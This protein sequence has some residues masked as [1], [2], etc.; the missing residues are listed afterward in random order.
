MLTKIWVWSHMVSL[1]RVISI[2]RISW[3]TDRKWIRYGC[4]LLLYI[5]CVLWVL[6]YTLHFLYLVLFLSL[7]DN[8]SLVANVI[9]LLKPTW[10]KVYLI[11]SYLILLWY[12][13][14]TTS[15]KA[16]FWPDFKLMKDT[17]NSSYGCLSWDNHYNDVIM[18]MTAS[19]ITRLM[20]VY[21]TAYS[22]ADQ[23]KHQSCTS[24][25]FVRGIHQWLV[26]SS[27]KGPVKRKMFPFDDVFIMGKLTLIYW[28]CTV[29]RR[30][31]QDFITIWW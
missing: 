30:L 1:C 12:A 11:L 24:L 25:A 29:L 3:Y 26:N 23:R 13:H 7:S 31:W 28:L 8:S 19:Q 22:G 17:P 18:S 10:N 21:S 16:K 15:L 5:L 2:P 27:H 6:F 14:R 4:V 20:I 9:C